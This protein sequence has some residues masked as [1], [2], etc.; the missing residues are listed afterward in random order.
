[1]EGNAPDPLRDVVENGGG[2]GRA[3]GEIFNTLAEDVLEPAKELPRSPSCSW[4]SGEDKGV[5]CIF[6]NK[7]TRSCSY[8]VLDLAEESIEKLL[9]WCLKVT[10]LRAG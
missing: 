6:D 3:G 9:S 5:V 2:R 1:M 8:V 10:C 7:D 4:R